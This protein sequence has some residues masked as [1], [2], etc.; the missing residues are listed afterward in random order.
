MYQG[1]TGFLRSAKEMDMAEEHKK[2][3]LLTR[4]QG[5]VMVVHF[6]DTRILDVVN[7]NQIAEELSD[8]VE[9][10]NYTRLLLNLTNVEYLSSAVLAKLIGLH[11]R[12]KELRGEL[13]VCSVR[14]SIMEVFRITKLDKV[15]DIQR[16]EEEGLARFKVRGF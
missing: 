3:R 16:T 5:D 12:L 13:R 4:A 1:K 8:I 7:I 11:K 10:K 14:D 9:K 6:L 2:S 15:F